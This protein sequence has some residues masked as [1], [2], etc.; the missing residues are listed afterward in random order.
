MQSKKYKFFDVVIEVSTPEN[1]EMTEPYALFL[2]DDKPKY[3]A[4]FEYVSELPPISENASVGNEIAFAEDSGKGV[5]WY[6]S[7]GSDKYFAYRT[8]CGN[9]ISVKVI[10]NFKGKLWNG[11]VFNLL[12]FEEIMANENA[13]VLHGS[14][15]KKNG[16]MIIFTAPCGTGKSTQAALWEKYADAEIVNG[17][18]CLV[19]YENGNI[20]AGGLVFSGSSAICKNLSAPL[21]AIVSL[22][23][24][25]ENILR[26]LS[27]GEALIA[28]LQGNYRSGITKSASQKTINVLEEAC[29]NV[30]MYRLDC[31]PD[32][33]AVECLK[34]ELG[35]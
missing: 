6:K 27:K 5:C 11:V 33:T 31:L 1:T 16:K 4:V 26:K 10:D 20:M 22:G 18:K 29:R 34:K 13:I 3:R 25:K 30:P 7:H 32:R 17:D 15:V 9:N 19:K 28:L 14:M 8:T 23:Q 35:I 2:T 12:G 21:S 24:A